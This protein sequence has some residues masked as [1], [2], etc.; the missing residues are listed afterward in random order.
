MRVL[1]MVSVLVLLLAMAPSAAADKPESVE[2]Q[3]LAVN[4]F[5]GALDP[6]LTKP[7]NTTD[8]TRWYYRGGAEYLANFVNSNAA[9]NPNTVKVSAGDMVGATPLLSA[10]FHDEP[11]VMAFNLM[12]WDLSNTG[13]HEY[14]EGWGELLRLDV[15]GCHILDGCY[16]GVPAFTG[17]EFDYLAANVIRLDTGETLFPATAVREFDGVKVGFIGIALETTPTIVVS[18]SV[19]GL[20]FQSEVEVINHYVKQLK[21]AEGLKAIVVILHDGAGPAANPN[22]CNASDP[23][24]A[25]VIQGLDPEVDV[26]ITGHTHNA[27]NCSVA[28]KKNFDPILVTSAGSNGRYLTSV[29]LTIAGTNGQV[30][31]RTA[32]NIPVETPY[33]G[34]VPDAAMKA[35]LD[36]YRAAS[37]PLANQIIGSI[38]ADIT[39][40]QNAAGE[41]ALGDVITDA[42]LAAT[43]PG[44]GEAVIAIT[45]PGG[46]RVDL[47]YNQISGGEA[48]GQV[49]FAE[50]FAVQP[51]S[52]SLVTMTLTGGQL[53]AVLEQQWVANRIL[54]VSASLTYSYSASAPVGSKVTDLKVNGVPVDPAATYRVT[55]N[56]YLAGGGD[57][58]SVFTEGTNMLTG[59]ID[60]DAFVAYF[61]THS[62]VAPGPQNRIT[63]LP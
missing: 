14:D 5:H 9:L 51:F 45:N 37:A 54:Q 23:F 53:K 18:S 17:A 22:A 10:L 59:M 2:V 50:A 28:V 58:F 24:F 46:I 44:Y 36:Q 61:E 57:G 13:N 11:T 4:D 52:N 48:P 63:L 16:E 56:N 15:G 26:V 12:G 8:Q 31:E 25:N 55:V 33:L 42:Q 34:A 47:L 43:G 35:L 7:G 29:N 1:S 49:T 38:T 6:S 39:R 21:D 20:E 27:Y 32:T 62:P 30:I 41:S 40:T 3:I 60:L 19:A